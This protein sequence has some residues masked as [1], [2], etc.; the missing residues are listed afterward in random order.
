MQT[1]LQITHIPNITDSSM[2]EAMAEFI[3]VNQI[4]Q[5]GTFVV[6]S[7]GCL[8]QYFID[9][10][11]SFSVNVILGRLP[12]DGSIFIGLEKSLADVMMP[13]DF[14]LILNDE[15]LAFSVK[16]MD[17]T[18]IVRINSLPELCKSLST[19]LLNSIKAADEP[20]ENTNSSDL[21]FLSELESEA[22]SAKLIESSNALTIPIFSFHKAY[23][24]DF[25]LKKESSNTKIV[26][27]VI[28]D[29]SLSYNS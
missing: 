12:D 27:I 15:F 5:A 18:F 23:G 16:A 1:E 14:S 8:S 2:D 22:S 24:S 25:S 3:F 17:S 20:Q 28:T 21:D 19:E 11:P 10:P 7:E 26:N 6:P 13:L 9:L 29:Q 4:V